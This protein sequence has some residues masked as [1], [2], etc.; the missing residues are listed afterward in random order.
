MIYWLLCISHP[1]LFIVYT[2]FIV[3]SDFFVS[4]I[5]KYRDTHTWMQRVMK[6]A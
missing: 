5:D 2:R 6:G 3:I 1:L 4:P